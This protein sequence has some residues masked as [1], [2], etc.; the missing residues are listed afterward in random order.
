[1]ALPASRCRR[2]QTTR[3]SALSHACQ[4]ERRCTLAASGTPGKSYIAYE[5]GVPAFTPG[6]LV[7]TSYAVSVVAD[8]HHPTPDE[9]AAALAAP[10]ASAAR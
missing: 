4:G 2:R 6:T 7:A 5:G 9:L 1:M 3:S 10:E 8:G